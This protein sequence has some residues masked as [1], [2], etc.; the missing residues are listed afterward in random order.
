MWNS[1]GADCMQMLHDTCHGLNCIDCQ[2]TC[3]SQHDKKA[4]HDGDSG[5]LLMVPIVQTLAHSVNPFF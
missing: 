4:D 1:A 3:K 5:L 2:E